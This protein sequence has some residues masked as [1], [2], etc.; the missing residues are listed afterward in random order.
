MDTADLRQIS[1]ALGLLAE[2]VQR[3]SGEDADQ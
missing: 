1:G 2:A 3:R